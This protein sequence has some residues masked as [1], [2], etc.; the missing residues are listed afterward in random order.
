[1]RLGEGTGAVLAMHLVEAAARILGEMATFA[2]AGVSEQGRGVMHDFLRA[3][4]L[5]TRLPVR[6]LGWDDDVL[7]GRAMA[8]YPL[9]GAVIGALLAG[10]AWLLT[11]VGG[12]RTGRRLGA[13]HRRC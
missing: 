7:P 12:C 9:V 2:E 6:A 11:A 5:L 3:L 4:S 8:A 13:G 10:L 1:M